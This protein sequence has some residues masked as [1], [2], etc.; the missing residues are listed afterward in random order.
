MNQ[1]NSLL[2]ISGFAG[3]GKSVLC[4]TAI[5]YISDLG[6]KEN[7]IALGFFYFQFDDASKQSDSLLIKSL[8]LQHQVNALLVT[9]FLSDYTSLLTRETHRFRHA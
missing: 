3:I 1:D 4:S 2:C 8:L 7:G 6:K 9:G 5:T